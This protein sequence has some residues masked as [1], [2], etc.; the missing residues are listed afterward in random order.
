[1]EEIDPV[2][3]GRGAGGGG[4]LE[5]SS[6]GHLGEHFLLDSQENFGEIEAA[7]IGRTR[8]MVSTKE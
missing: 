6:D 4:V 5:E 2:L 8:H 1:M 3:F 7:G